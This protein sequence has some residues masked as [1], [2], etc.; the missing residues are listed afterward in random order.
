[1]NT[2]LLAAAQKYY[3]GKDP[4]MIDEEYDRLLAVAVANNPSFNIFYHIETGHKRIPH[5]TWIATYSKP[6]SRTKFKNIDDAAAI[7]IF[8]DDEIVMPKYDGCSVSAYYHP[9]TGKL[10][11]IITRSNEVTGMDKTEYFRGKV[12]AQVPIGVRR[13]DYEAI[14]S[15]DEFGSSARFKAN[16]LVTSK[17]KKREANEKLHFAPFFVAHRPGINAPKHHSLPSLFI[18]A[19]IDDRFVSLNVN[20][21]RRYKDSTIRLHWKT[22][23][24]D[25][26]VFY[27]CS[28]P[29]SFYLRKYHRQSET[30]AK[31]V[32]IEWNLSPKFNFI[33]KIILEDGVMVDGTHIKRVASG[34][35]R[36]LRRLRC[37]IG[38]TVGVVRAGSTIPKISRVLTTSENYGQ[39][40]CSECKAELTL[41]KTDMK[42][43]WLDCKT[44]R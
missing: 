31:V 8:G 23:P 20:K 24:I 32:N 36:N 28:D 10:Y 19:G 5:P 39:M 13:I 34:G 29:T 11:R 21:L 44:R 15:I 38:A 30:I 33:P 41:H 7:R 4:Q 42:C 12:P 6:I 22:Y 37:G 16:G 25:G 9:T 18:V 2:K 3:I 14:V 17:K 27:K 40:I 43:S 26:F 1:M 35:H